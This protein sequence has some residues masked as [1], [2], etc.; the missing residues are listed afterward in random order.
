M[1]IQSHSCNCSAIYPYKFI[2]QPDLPVEKIKDC[3]GDPEADV[4]NDVLKIEQDR[5]VHI[6]AIS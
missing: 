3:M 6:P 4:E 5:Q 1:C 2:G